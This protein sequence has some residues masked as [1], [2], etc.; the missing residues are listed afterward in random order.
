M[1]LKLIIS[2]RQ[3]QSSILGTTLDCVMKSLSDRTFTNDYRMY[4]AQRHST[5]NR[6]AEIQPIICLT[7][8]EPWLGVV[9]E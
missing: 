5:E 6:G 4:T 8:L 2:S 3:R 1:V 7:R 9:S